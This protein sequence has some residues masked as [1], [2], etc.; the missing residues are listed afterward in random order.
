MFPHPVTY[1][2]HQSH[3]GCGQH[4]GGKG[5]NSGGNYCLGWAGNCGDGGIR[6]LHKNQVG[7]S[8]ERNLANSSWYLLCEGCRE[9]YV[10]MHRGG[11]QQNNKTKTMNRR[12][13]VYVKPLTSPSTSPGLE[14]HVIMKNNAMFLLDLASSADTVISRQRR[15]SSSVMPS[16]SENNSP[17]DCGGP[18]SPVPPFQCL[19][20]LG[21]SSIPNEP[22]FYEKVLRQQSLHDG[23]TGQRVRSLCR[24]ISWCLKVLFQ[25]LSEVSISDNDSDSSKGLRFHRSVSMGTNGIPWSKTGFDGRIIMLRKRNNSSSEIANGTVIMKVMRVMAR[26][27]KKAPKFFCI[28]QLF[29]RTM[30]NSEFKSRSRPAVVHYKNISE[31]GPIS[32]NEGTTKWALH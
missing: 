21:A 13:S 18:F 26:L 15:P 1:H 12:K 19:Q 11:K 24:N 30:G 16:V 10:K 4:A 3:P 5:Y 8:N 22:E 2:M 27:E 14:P 32:A 23:N 29:I 31:K 7:S 17:P 25:P 9:K 20:A 28:V 6:K